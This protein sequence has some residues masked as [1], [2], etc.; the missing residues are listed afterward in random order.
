MVF[1]VATQGGGDSCN[2]QQVATTVFSN[3]VSDATP[4][5]SQCD[6]TNN[7]AVQSLPEVEIPA[8]LQQSR[9]VFRGTYGEGD[10][11]PPSPRPGIGPFPPGPTP[12]PRPDAIRPGADQPIQPGPP[13]PAPRQ[14]G[15]FTPDQVR[16]ILAD[17]DKAIALNRGQK[18]PG[19]GG[20]GPLPPSPDGR[21]PFRPDNIRPDGLNPDGFRP[22]GVRPD[23][24]RPEKVEFSSNEF[25]KA[26][27]AA[28]DSGR[29][30]VISFTKPRCGACTEI[31]KAWNSQQ[32]VIP[33]NAI[34]V[35]IN[36]DQQ[37][38]LAKNMNVSDYPTT[39]VVR[40]RENQQLEVIDS[41]VG[42]MS[43]DDL[44]GFLQRAFQKHRGGG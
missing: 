21:N 36:G 39:M 29:P 23:S 15:G 4:I 19:P 28:T 35:K 18:P 7:T 31:D 40:P 37:R 34:R 1:D 24:P 27:K 33:D 44:R 2:E 42:A 12:T 11:P 5:T 30:L 22:D 25:D 14:D 16:Q 43:G 9:G 3:C 17:R 32:D 10:T 38:G 6:T 13:V 20:N 41:S 26:V 8:N